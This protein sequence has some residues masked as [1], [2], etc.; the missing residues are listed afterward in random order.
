MG[1]AFQQVRSNKIRSSFRPCAAV[2]RRSAEKILGDLLGRIAY[3]Q[4]LRLVID[5]DA[6]PIVRYEAV[7]ARVSEV[8]LFVQ[9]IALSVC[10]EGP[11]NSILNASRSQVRDGH[12][13]SGVLL[14]APHAFPRVLLRASHAF[15]RV[16]LRAPHTLSRVLL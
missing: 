7:P 6:A 14:R 10:D 8:E 4:I 3:I 15:S 11:A 16:L 1:S 9:V 5:Q 2:F 12:I 13:F